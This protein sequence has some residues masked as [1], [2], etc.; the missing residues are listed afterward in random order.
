MLARYHKAFTPSGDK[1]DP[2]AF[3]N[4]Q[5]AKDSS[6]QATLRPLAF[7]WIR[8]VFRCWQDRTRY[9]ETTYLNA[10]KRRGSSL[11]TFISLLLSFDGTP[12]GVS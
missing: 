11:L 9:D 5:P 12:Q 8:I 4:Q 7:K 3:Y 6:H 10:L 1:D 2:R